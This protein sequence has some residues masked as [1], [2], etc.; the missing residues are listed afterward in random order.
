M[1]RIYAKI[2]PS[3]ISGTGLFSAQFIPKGAT[4]WQYDSKFDTS[5][6]ESDVKE[7]PE[8]ARE[9][10]LKYA[11]FDHD[12]SKYILCSDYQRFINH[13]PSPNIS[14]TPTLDIAMRDIDEGEELTCDYAKYEHDW[15]ERRNLSREDFI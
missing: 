2:G 13:S 12:L 11:Y 4:T 1:L 15:F 10:F 8:V 6:D 9:P 3:K 5:F 7:M 14:S